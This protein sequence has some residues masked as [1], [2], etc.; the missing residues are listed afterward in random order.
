[1]AGWLADVGSRVLERMS[2]WPGEKMGQLVY[3]ERLGRIG[4]WEERLGIL[5]EVEIS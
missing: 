3:R 1:M 2:G 5:G 4:V